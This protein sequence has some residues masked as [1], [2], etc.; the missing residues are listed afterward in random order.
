MLLLLL[1]LQVVLPKVK[2][3]V[4]EDSAIERWY[5]LWRAEYI[6]KFYKEIC[7]INLLICALQCL[8]EMT[9]RMVVE[10]LHQAVSEE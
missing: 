5:L 6:I 10:C 8:F 2:S 7:H 9:R 1:L 4:F 3:G